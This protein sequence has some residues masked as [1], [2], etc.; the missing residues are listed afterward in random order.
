MFAKK[1]SII[2]LKEIFNPTYQIAFSINNEKYVMDIKSRIVLN[3]H[4]I[5]P[6]IVLNVNV[7]GKVQLEP[8]SKFTVIVSKVKDNGFVSLEDYRDFNKI[9]DVESYIEEW[10]KKSDSQ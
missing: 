2:I 3:I 9:N 5:K 1:R 10:K 4:D 6:K 7:N 8:N